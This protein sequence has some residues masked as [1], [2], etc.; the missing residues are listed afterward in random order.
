MNAA[1]VLLVE[2]NP[3][4]ALLVRELLDE[5]GVRV[6]LEE[7]PNLT[8]AL[9]RL[10]ADTWE[11]V[12]LDLSLP[13]AQGIETVRRVRRANPSVPI[14]VLSGL[15]D[16][17]TAL[18]AVQSGAQDYL[19]KGHVSGFQLARAIAYSTERAR[20]FTEVEAARE[21]SAFLAGQLERRNAQLEDRTQFALQAA[22]MVAWDWTLAGDRI[23][24]SDTAQEVLGIESSTSMT[25]KMVRVLIHPDDLPGH[26]R[27]FI[28]GRRSGRGYVSRYRFWHA[29]RREYIWLEEHGRVALSASGRAVRAS[30]LA[31][32]V[33]ERVRAEKAL[34]E[35]STFLSAT[36]DSL[37]AHVAV[38]AADGTILAVNAAWRAYGQA[39][40]GQLEDHGVGAN[41]LEVCDRAAD[42]S[43]E[44]ALMAQ[45]LRDVISGKTNDLVIE[46]PCPSPAEE[47]WYMV[48][49]TRFR[50]G[51]DRVA[52]AH[53]NIT[54]RVRAEGLLRRV[55]EAQKRFVSDAAH[56]LRAPLTAIQGN[57]E[58]LIRHPNISAE[59]RA[60]SLSDAHREAARLGRLVADLLSVA[61]G[62]SGGILYRAPV[63]F[64]VVIAEALRDARLLSSSHTFAEGELEP[65]VVEGDRDKL[66]QLSLIL[67]ENAI[68]YTPK[69]GQISVRLHCNPEWTT[70]EVSDSGVGISSDDLPHVFERFYRA[71]RAR[72]RGEDPG[73]TGLGLPIAKWIVESHGGTIQIE[74]QLGQGTLVRVRLPISGA[75]ETP[76]ERGVAH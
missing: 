72:S 39:N 50:D 15:G 58:L 20:L 76:L 28:A 43:P 75:D 46:Y 23:A 69:G 42:T 48:R 35:S 54:E 37:G 57:L 1:R 52:V 5:A 60:D 14:V 16:D 27:H 53:E 11:A 70:L 29:R 56:E 34:E 71:D 32:D 61:R 6:E 9:E 31:Q 24:L 2:D 40:G 17:A 8:R 12:L 21:R 62:D 19:V 30:G 3:G 49:V 38:L 25:S 66:K 7:V 10:L 13:D 45:G 36:L 51:S 67:M 33:T 41:Y 74:S 22:R 47:F 4:D 55:N 44:A 26:S 68:K 73:G 64:E 59:D 18:A 63:Q 65:C